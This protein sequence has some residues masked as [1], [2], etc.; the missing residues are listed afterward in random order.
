MQLKMNTSKL[1]TIEQVK[2]FLTG[3]KEISYEGV[4]REESNEWV[5]RV[6]FEFK[7]GKLKR[8]DKAVIRAYIEH[9]T[10]YKSAQISR[11]I[12]AYKL[13]GYVHKKDYKRHSFEKK[14]NKEDVKLL[15]QTDNLHQLNGASTKRLFSPH[16]K[17]DTDI[18][19]ERTLESGNSHSLGLAKKIV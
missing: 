18:R 2:E 12:K 17:L 6:L 7:Y 11:K 4:R 8:K 10:G 13:T 14:Y 19:E 15:A 3:T 9:V 16:S 1:R 5:E